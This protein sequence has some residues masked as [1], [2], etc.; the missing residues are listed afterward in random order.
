VLGLARLWLNQI[1]K[2]AATSVARKS[3]CR[4]GCKRYRGT[5][6]Q[7][8]RPLDRHDEGAALAGAVEEVPCLTAA[9]VC[10]REVAPPGDGSRGPPPGPGPA[11]ASSS[12]SSAPG[13]PTPSSGPSSSDHHRPQ[14][15]HHPLHVHDGAGRGLLRVHRHRHRPGRAHPDRHQRRHPLDL[16]HRP[17][18]QDAHY[19]YAANSPCNYIDPTGTSFRCAVAGAAAGFLGATVGGGIGLAF[20]PVF[21]GFGLAAGGLIAAGFVKGYC[22]SGASTRRGKVLDGVANIRDDAIQTLGIA[23][24]TALGAALLAA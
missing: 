2:R 17:G 11:A 19:T 18:G 21:A 14:R 6:S 16:G 4:R 15:Q 23:A 9:A 22:D 20:T 24:A 13:R 12:S 7:V 5:A 1:T 10:A 8:R 3:A